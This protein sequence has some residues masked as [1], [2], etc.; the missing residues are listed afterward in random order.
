MYS[1]E[2]HFLRH[3]INTDLFKVQQFDSPINMNDQSFLEK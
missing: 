1:K 2:A 3:L